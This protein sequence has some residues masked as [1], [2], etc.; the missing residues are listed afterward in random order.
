[1]SPAAAAARPVKAAGLVHGCS[2]ASAECGAL[3]GA[4][5][6]AQAAERAPRFGAADP[7]GPS[8]VQGSHRCAVDVISGQVA[9]ALSLVRVP[10]LL[11][12]KTQDM[13]VGAAALGLLISWCWLTILCIVCMVLSDDLQLRRSLV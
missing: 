13:L 2:G 12:V 4:P 8:A 5:C 9:A 6:G 3:G 11:T 7:A 1:M 10:C